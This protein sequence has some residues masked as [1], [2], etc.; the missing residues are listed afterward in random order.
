MTNLTDRHE[1][2]TQVVQYLEGAYLSADQGAED[3][4]LVESR[5]ILTTFLVR[6]GMVLIS[7]D[8]MW[9]LFKA[10]SYLTDALLAV[11][12][13]INAAAGMLFFIIN[14]F[15][16]KSYVGEIQEIWRISSI[17]NFKQWSL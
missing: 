2:I 5:V 13:D 7:F 6:S 8:Y 1:H 15:A 3:R 17:Y 11:V 16:M 14:S 9:V 10:K 4:A 12:S